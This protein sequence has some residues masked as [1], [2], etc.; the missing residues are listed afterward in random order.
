MGGGGDGRGRC[1][2]GE[3]EAWG[4]SEVMG[5]HL[6]SYRNISF[7]PFHKLSLPLT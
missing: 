6:P 1:G 7:T 4:G 3:G 5:E 2:E